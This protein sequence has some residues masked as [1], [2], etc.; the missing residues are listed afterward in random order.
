VQD[1]K[2]SVQQL[3]D[4]AGISVSRFARFEVGAG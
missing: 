2:K 4:E 3:L 1:Q